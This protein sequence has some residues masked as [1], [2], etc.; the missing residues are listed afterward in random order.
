MSEMTGTPEDAER[1]WQ[2]HI[3]GEPRWYEQR[4]PEIKEGFFAGF[5]ARPSVTV[6]EITELLAGHEH[7][8]G[9]GLETLY[10]GAGCDWS[11][12]G[13]ME[14]TEG[15]LLRSNGQDTEVPAIAAHRQHVASV[16]VAHITGEG[17]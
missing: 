4:Y 13:Y 3:A 15:L 14:A 17:A 10:C 16:I 12:D 2:A 6:D 8:W 5:A 1:A 9:D 7:E 11:A